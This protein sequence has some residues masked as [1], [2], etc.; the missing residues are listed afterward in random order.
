MT[1][2]DLTDGLFGDI[3]A[4]GANAVH[5]VANYLLDKCGL[6]YA[7]ANLQGFGDL[8]D[9]ARP[10]YASTSGPVSSGQTAHAGSATT[11]KRRRPKEERLSGEEEGDSQ[12]DPWTNKRSKVAEWA[13]SKAA[14]A[15][16]AGKQAK[17]EHMSD[18]VLDGGR[19]DVDER[20]KRDIYKSDNE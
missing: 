11:Q 14:A 9:G 3:A 13:V 20:T 19:R 16:V 7:G 5:N 15:R 6:S 18:D 2:K 4:V 8:G 10:D 17:R 12:A 1:G